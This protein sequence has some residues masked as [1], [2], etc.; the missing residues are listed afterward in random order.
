MQ[1]RVEVPQSVFV[2]VSF[3]FMRLAILILVT[4][5]S[6]AVGGQPVHEAPAGAPSSGHMTRPEEP[7]AT[8]H[9]AGVVVASNGTPVAGASLYIYQTDREG[10][11][12][13]K[14]ASDSGNPRLKLFL[15]ADARGAW[16]FDTI[17]PGFVSRQP[18][19]AAHPL[20]SLSHGIRAAH[21]RDCV[22]G[23]SLRHQ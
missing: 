22:R 21:L 20:R 8:L 4:V 11:Y 13:V 14:P 10:Y 9:V 5:S 19:A 23:R 16:S 6:V 7:G 2:K 1:N 15:R 17:R 3:R 12:G 18:R